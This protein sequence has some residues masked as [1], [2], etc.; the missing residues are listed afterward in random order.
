M[1]QEKMQSTGAMD[2]STVLRAIQEHNA[3]MNSNFSYVSKQIR[4]SVDVTGQQA[5]GTAD[6]SV[7]L[8]ELHASRLEG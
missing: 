8:Q 5:N 3:E 6:L 4:D 7:V 2:F 1:I